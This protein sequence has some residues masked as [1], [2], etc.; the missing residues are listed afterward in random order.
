MINTMR[1]LSILFALLCTQPAL[2]H[3]LYLFAQYDGYKVSGKA[4]YSDMTPAAETYLVISQTGQTA[5]ILEGKT[6]REGRFTYPLHIEG[7]VKVTVEGEEGHKASVV[8]D[9]VSAQ[10][11][12][13]SD[14]LML[15][16]EDIAKLK[17]KIYLHDIL[18]GVGYILGIV[19]LWALVKASRMT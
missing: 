7:G 10:A 3:S 14:S 19:G 4:Y 8:A 15:L 17:D 18:G 12:A 2:A 5:P 1:F 16:R 9:R 6:D 13:D 11:T